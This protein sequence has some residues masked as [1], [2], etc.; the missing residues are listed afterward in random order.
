M[1]ALDTE[2]LWPAVEA[3]QAHCARRCDN[4]DEEPLPLSMSDNGPQMRAGTTREFL[5]LC[6]IASRFGRPGTPTD[7]AWIETLFGH[8]KNRMAPPRQDHRPQHAASR[9]RHRPTRLQHPPPARLL[10]L[11]PPRRRTPRPRRAHP[12]GPD[13]TASTGPASPASPTTAT[14]NPRSH[15]HT[16]PMWRNQAPY[17][18]HLLRSTSRCPFLRVRCVVC[19]T[20]HPTS[21]GPFLGREPTQRQHS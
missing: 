1:Q 18:G 11:G 4:G 17:N 13:E 9:A 21:K 12:P 15:E 10:R 7:Q 8:V 20:H 19:N 5:A 2:G 6:C 16:H 14:T 3:R